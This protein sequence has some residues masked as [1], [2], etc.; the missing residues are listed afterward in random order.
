V[1]I[2]LKSKVQQL[3]AEEEEDEEKNK[4]R[5]FVICVHSQIYSC[6]SCR[7]IKM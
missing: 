2:P 6:E 7:V 4:T 1:F 3:T 5:S